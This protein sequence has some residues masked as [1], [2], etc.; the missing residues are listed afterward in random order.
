MNKRERDLMRDKMFEDLLELVSILVENQK[1]I[2]KKLDKLDK[3]KPVK[4]TKRSLQ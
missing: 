4:K 2:M 1:S 3:P